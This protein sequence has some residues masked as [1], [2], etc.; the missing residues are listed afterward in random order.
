MER[1]EKILGSSVDRK[2]LTYE[3]Q[4][5]TRDTLCDFGFVN[6]EPSSHALTEDHAVA[7]KSR[8]LSQTF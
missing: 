4:S 1:M 6:C 3:I 5:G 2:R 8:D 7:A